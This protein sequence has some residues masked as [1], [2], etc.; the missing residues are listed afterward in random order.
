MYT[1]TRVCS[2]TCVYIG[3]IKG[4]HYKFV[5]MYVCVYVCVYMYVCA[6]VHLYVGVHVW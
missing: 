5:C 4:L 2:T 3:V 1:Y 6:C